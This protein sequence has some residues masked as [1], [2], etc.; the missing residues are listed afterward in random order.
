M[1]CRGYVK[2]NCTPKV[3]YK[4]FVVQFMLDNI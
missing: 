1:P 2:L 3:E 4:T